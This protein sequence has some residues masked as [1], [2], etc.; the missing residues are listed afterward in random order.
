M[1]WNIS[2]E[3]WIVFIIPLVCWRLYHALD[4]SWTSYCIVISCRKTNKL[5]VNAANVQTR[6]GRNVR[7][8]GAYRAPGRSVSAARAQPQRI[9]MRRARGRDVTRLPDAHCCRIHSSCCQPPLS[10]RL[11]IAFY[12]NILLRNFIL[13]RTLSIEWGSYC[14]VRMIPLNH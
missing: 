8:R 10:K 1:R 2:N 4:L 14:I 13:L 9:S 12:A 11:T 3:P 5:V 7:M 6:A